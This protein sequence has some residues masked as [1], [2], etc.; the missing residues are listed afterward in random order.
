MTIELENL[1]KVSMNQFYAGIHWTKRKKLKDVYK[2]LIRSQ[3]K[4]KIDYVCSV[5]YM[6]L[7]KNNPLDCSNC[8]GMAKMVEDCLFDDDSIKIVKSIKIISRKANKDILIITIDKT[9]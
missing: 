9:E 4:V 3:T 6:F 1:P 8:M 5:T 2:L 7:F